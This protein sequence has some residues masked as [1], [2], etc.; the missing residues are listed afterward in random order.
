MVYVPPELSDY[1]I[2]FLYDDRPTLKAC[3]LISRAWYPAARYHLYRKV[4]LPSFQSCITY[5][6]LIENSLTLASYTREVKI[7]NAL[8]LAPRNKGQTDAAR[9]ELS[10]CWA[11]VFPALTALT[12]LE[13]SFL[14][15]HPT[16]GINLIQHLNTVNDLS[17]QYC[18]FETFADFAAVFC[19]FPAL[20]SCVLRGVSWTGHAVAASPSDGTGLMFPRLTT[21]NLGRDLPLEELQQWLLAERVCDGLVNFSGSCSSERDAILMSELLQLASNTLKEVELDWYSCSYDGK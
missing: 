16:L 18:R 8:P 21:L 4:S 15:I 17:L 6:S 12:R 13:L 9:E 5:R 1:I 10:H 3:S 20:Q 2:D 19:S 11:F 14:S 7:A